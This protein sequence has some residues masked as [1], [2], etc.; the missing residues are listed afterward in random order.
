MKKSF[1]FCN[2]YFKNTNKSSFYPTMMHARRKCLDNIPCKNSIPS[3]SLFFSI[4]KKKA[5]LIECITAP[6]P[7]SDA[8]FQKV[9][10]L[11]K[12]TVDRLRTPTL[13]SSSYEG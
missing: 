7:P 2:K 12:F 1:T 6:S 13:V 8:P 10:V 4:M 11:S 5:A 9:V 3:H